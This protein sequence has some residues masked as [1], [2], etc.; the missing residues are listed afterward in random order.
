MSFENKTAYLFQEAVYKL[1]KNP[2][3]RGKY[4]NDATEFLAMFRAYYLD[5]NTPYP[6]GLKRISGEDK[7]TTLARIVRAGPKMVNRE[8]SGDNVRHYILWLIYNLI[9]DTPNLKKTPEGQFEFA[10]RSNHLYYLIRNFEADFG[11]PI[12][13]EVD[14]ACGLSRTDFINIIREQYQI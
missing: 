10:Q 6:Y 1:R 12:I 2:E 3:F 8:V 14:L 4:T 13:E 9:K 5:N 7:T 11:K